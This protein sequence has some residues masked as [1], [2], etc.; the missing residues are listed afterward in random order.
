ME[1]AEAERPKGGASTTARRV[2]GTAAILAFA[3]ALASPAYAAINANKAFA[4][5]VVSIGQV[6]KVTIFFLNPNTSAATSLA[7]TDAL[8]AGVTIAPAPNTASSCGGSIA[9]NTG[10]TSVSFS[11]GSV[12]AAVGATPGS[13]QVSFDVVANAA[14]IYINA[15][16]VGDVTS[17]QG[18]NSQRAEASLTVTSL[19]PI[20][21][22]KAFLPTVVH[23]NGSPSTATITLRNA[24]GVALTNVGM[25]DTLPA[26]LVVASP[27]VTTNG[28][29]GTLTAAPG[30][31][32]VTLAGGTIPAQV[33]A[34]VGT[35]AITFRVA[36]ADATTLRNG[37]VT[38]TIAAASM[39]SAEG[40]TNTAF[41]GAIRLQSGM[42]LVKAFAPT[43]ILSGGTSTL[44]VTVRNFNA[45]ALGALAFTDNL[46]APSGTP[47]RIAAAP[48]TGGTCLAAP[49]NAT[50]SSAVA[51]AT[52]FTTSG[53]SLAATDP[54]TVSNT[55]CTFTID[56]TATNPGPTQRT[57][58][59]TILASNFGGI[60]F[61]NTSGQLV[62]N[63]PSV[64][65]GSKVFET[66]NGPAVRTN[67]IRARVTINNTSASNA[68]NV[69]MNDLLTT[70]GAGYTFAG[71]AVEAATSTCG[72]AFNV[73]AAATTTVSFTGGAINAGASC[74]L[75]FPVNIAANAVTGTRTNTIA[76]S[77]ISATIA[78]ATV[79]NTVPITGQI[80]VGVALSVAKAFAPTLVPAGANS[81]LTITVTHANGAVP[82]TA[83]AFTDTLPAGHVVAAT[84]NVSNTCGGTVTAT[85]LAGTVSL[86]S[87]S[88]GTGLTTCQVAVDI[89]TPA[90]SGS[91]TN[92]LAVDSVTATVVPHW[93]LAVTST[94]SNATAATANLQRISGVVQLAKSFAP[95]TVPIAT[96]SVMTLR[97]LNNA[98]GA[99]N[100]TAVALTDTLPAGMIVANPPAATFTGT[101]CSPG[102]VT[103]VNNSG[104][105]AITGKSINAGSICTIT[106]TVRAA[107]AGNL[108][109]VLPA[110]AVSSTQGVSNLDPVAATLSSTGVANVSVTKTDGVT[111]VAAGTS[112]TYTIVVANA[113]GSATVAGATFTDA[114]P[115]GATFTSWSCVAT[116]G[117]SCTANGTGAISDTVTIPAAGS[118][119]YTVTA[120]V[121]PGAS[122]T[123]VN[124]ASV[125]LPASVI[126][127]NPANNSASDTDTIVQTVALAV[128]KTDGSATYVPGGTGTYVVTVTNS[129][130]S[131]GTGITFGDTLPDAV[132][133][134]TPGVS[135]AS[136]GAASCGTAGA[137]TV[138]TQA[139]SFTGMQIAAGAGNDVQVTI[140]VAYPASMTV[141]PLVNT[142]TATHVA[143]GN[144][145]NGQDSSARTPDIAL[146]VTKTD[147][148]ATYVPGGTATYTVVATNTGV[149]DALSVAVADTLPAGVTLNATVTCAPSASSNCGTVT[150]TGGQTAFGAT[151]AVI[152]GGGGTL[153]FTVPVAFGIGMTD[154]SIT[155]TATATATDAQLPPPGTVSAQGSDTDTRAPVDLGIAKSHAGSF[156]Q[157][158]AGATF[159]IVVTNNGSSPSVGPVTVTDVLPA[160]LTATSIAGTNWTCTSPGGPCTRSDALLPGA[161]YETITLTVDVATSA[162]TPLVNQ[163]TVSGGGDPSD[164]TAN[165]SVVVNPGRDLA[166][167]K[168]HAGNFFQGQVGAQFTIGVNNAGGTA[169]TGTVTVTDSLPAGLTATAMTGTGWTCTPPA[170]PC[171]R[172]DALAAGASYPVIT[173]TVD[174]SPTAGTSLLNMA[175]V[176][177]GGDINPANNIANDFVTVVGGPDLAIAKSHTGNFFQGQ[178]G[179]TFAISVQNLGLSAGVG[180]VTV[181][182]TLPAGLAATAIGGTG[183]SCTPATLTC[184]RSDPLASAASYPAIT[185]TVD[186]A[187]NA[188]SSVL[189][190]A[191]VAGGGDVN[192]AN[193][194]AGDTVTVIGGPDPTIAKSHSGN[195]FQGQIG[196]QFA[197][198]VQNLGNSATVGT[199]TVA[200][201][202][203]TGLTATAISGSGWS[204][205]QPGGPCTRS[206][207]LASAA[208]YPA[209]TLTVDVS[210]TAGT[211]LLNTA[212]VAGGGDVNPSNNAAGDFVTV[213][214]G[215]E[216][217]IAKSHIGNFFQGQ[218]GATFAITVQNLGYTASVGTVTVTDTLPAGLTATAIGGTG[219][220]CTL[221][222]LVCTRS[223]PLASAASYPAITV[224]VDVSA[225]ATSP[226]VNTATVAGGG[227][228]FPDNNTATDSVTVALGPD[229]RI[230]KTHPGAFT[231]GQA[232]T[233][234]ITVSNAGNAATVGTVTVTDT[235]PSGLTATAIGGTGWSCTLA[236][237][238][239]TRGDALAAGAS[240]PVITLSVNVA[241]PA[242]DSVVNTASVAGGGDVD[243][244]NND[245]SDPTAIVAARRYPVPAASALGLAWT[246]A[247][248]LLFGAVALWRRRDS[249]RR[250]ADER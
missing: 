13:C 247:L 161:S 246:S 92:S 46:P 82:F 154:P 151:A 178:V 205:T 157:G 64:L 244:S 31:G 227:D 10:D 240:Y 144:A 159:S 21:G 149:S 192:P 249:A 62:V 28:C 177:G 65:T 142:A 221:A 61:P 110:G 104:V 152:R 101:G 85:P 16:E 23:G 169:T 208:S 248:L 129:G 211:S 195:F 66:P 8:P 103:A 204:C 167:S 139:V 223:D 125:A 158:Q 163:A 206:D 226:L 38:N 91:V 175:T 122:G 78:A 35:C 3:A 108:I 105:V 216:L 148:N 197:L 224:T 222:T 213:I 147:G 162:G 118:L 69:A 126:D 215:P 45:S 54:L 183:W 80:A 133:I 189:N 14:D 111:Q 191:T 156:F 143:T 200:D 87:G 153:T 89:T 241:D 11:A 235:L 6:S 30:G 15:I 117:G 5:D 112:T 95:A 100:L 181:T 58:T 218:V 74:V 19:A 71:A 124:T 202:L 214:G 107:S 84:P 179:A 168:T 52:S 40:V 199:V 55:E 145:A 172:S 134:A 231:A 173:L 138:G 119:T 160:G 97:I 225:S 39:T 174:V 115:A 60:P 132:V 44:T 76:T 116:A 234:A 67:W 210:P 75:T 109:N 128:A 43:P 185:L 188:P 102:G 120:A 170:G 34:V 220:S 237:L 201:T 217:A 70:M 131:N 77:G 49:T 18:G 140:P 37:N 198:T 242:P 121:A 203:P 209:I 176:A 113:A 86:S 229:L 94:V 166:I 2:A 9:A 42:Q 135:C 146:A 212:T 196:A 207:P 193:N 99:V 106:V 232:G 165:D 236:T 36:T 53:G 141:T 27:V 1:H 228:V 79:V 114:E 90:G 73:P 180:T 26:G 130:P 243:P 182:D 164:A 83:L 59:N 184:T 250:R 171:T 127:G 96:T 190:T 72:G 20:T 123:L 56:V 48:N 33:G 93:P 47:M 50:F 219:W 238:T 136:T 12:P 17:S 63:A 41:S 68:T 25:L 4:P 57:Y 187:P 7:F 230:A 81:R 245:A 239:C 29:G 88:L 32:T 233:Y 150:G 186:V 51:N 137:N 194:S 22:T 24:N 98:P 155:N